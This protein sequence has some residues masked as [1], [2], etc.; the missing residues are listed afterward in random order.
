MENISDLRLNVEQLHDVSS[1]L[2]INEVT[3]GNPRFLALLLLCL[4]LKQLV[5]QVIEL[6]FQVNPIPFIVVKLLLVESLLTS[7]DKS[8]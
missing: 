5:L 7:E 4:I 6:L 3:P 8:K 2:D 1:I